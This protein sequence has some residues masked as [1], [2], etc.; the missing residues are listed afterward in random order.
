MLFI[1]LTMFRYMLT[2]KLC[3]SL[4]VL[5]LNAQNNEIAPNPQPLQ[6]GQTES[7]LIQGFVSQSSISFCVMMNQP[8]KA[9]LILI[10]TQN[11]Q[12]VES[13]EIIPEEDFCYQSNCSLKVNF[14]QLTSNTSYQLHLYNDKELTKTVNFTTQ[15]ESK[16]IKDFSIITGSCGFTPIGWGKMI[17]PF[18]S[19]KIYS[20]MQQ[21]KADFMLWLGDTV[22]YIKDDNL[23]RKVRRNILYRKEEKL[24][25]FLET[26]P[27][28]A[29]WDDHDFGPNN[30]DGSYKNKTTTLSVFNQFWPNPKSIETNGMYFKISQ[31]DVDFFVLDNRSYSNKSTNTNASILGDTQK[32]WLK[33]QLKKS[34]ANFKII[35]SGNQFIADYLSDKTFALYPKERQEIFDYLIAHKI[36]GVFFLTGDRHH[37][38]MLNRKIDNLYTLY[39]Y[40]CSPITS[41]PNAKLNSLRFNKNQ[42]IKGTL[43]NK[44]NFGKLS[45]T[46]DKDDRTCIIETIDKNG[47]QKGQ[48]KIKA[49]DL[50]FNNKAG[51]L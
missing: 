18:L 28:I 47:K 24:M 27:Q 50:C 9:K 1:A 34:T 17:F 43:F 2:V 4:Y 35:C 11:Q 19:L 38:E 25:Q 22:Y 5:S 30:A 33:D 41:W 48:F 21:A 15:P 44:R 10:N 49:K 3:F 16:E 23:K 29:M 46:G 13:K 14:D 51:D 8:A 31:Y 12:I 40:S 45:F 20:K 7:Q 26:T 6:K 36:E 37:T 39:E 42:R 32:T